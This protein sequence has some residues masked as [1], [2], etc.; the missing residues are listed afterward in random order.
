M[1]YLDIVPAGTV[2]GTMYHRAF[3]SSVWGRTEVGLEEGVESWA[4][5]CFADFFSLAQ[6]TGAGLAC[7]GIGFGFVGCF[8]GF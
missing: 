4:W 2:H 3:S 6:A 5:T 7:L 8:F 1:V